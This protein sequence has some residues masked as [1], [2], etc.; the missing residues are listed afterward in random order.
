LRMFTV[1]LP[2]PGFPGEIRGSTSCHSLETLPRKNT[3]I[4]QQIGLPNC[5]ELASKS[6]R[7]H[8]TGICRALQ[9]VLCWL[10]MVCFFGGPRPALADPVGGIP[11]LFYHQISTPEHPLPLD[12]TVVDVAAFSRQMQF[13]HDS[14]YRTIG[15]AEL[16]GLIKSGGH[17]PEKTVAIHF[18]DG[19]KTVLAAAPILEKYKFKAAFWI[20]VNMVGVS[21]Y[22]N[23]DD[24]A[25]LV[26]SSNYEIY[27]HTMSHSW[28]GH[29][30]LL[31][32]SANDPGKVDWEL[33]E[34][35]RQ[36]E[37]RLGRPVPFLAWPY[38]EYNDALIPIPHQSDLMM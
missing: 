35:K 30:D 27:S 2:P 19:W 18:D 25:G 37:Q 14:G 38:G 12:D 16:M 29:S 31:D 34:S 36:L 20:I 9:G 17:L 1:R 4:A 23:W 10:A 26:R 15:T 13:L 8:M 24:L 28:H 5:T 21:D 33:R 7:D 32:W 3:V 22:L 6:G 11:V